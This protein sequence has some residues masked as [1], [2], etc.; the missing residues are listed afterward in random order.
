MKTRILLAAPLFLALA[1]CGAVN[2][3]AYI[4]PSNPSGTILGTAKAPSAST[5]PSETVL[6]QQA[7]ER[8]AFQA[9]LTTPAILQPDD[10]ALACLRTFMDAHGIDLVAAANAPSAA[11]P[12]GFKPAPVGL[13]SDLMVGY[14]KE[15]MV[16]NKLNGKIVIS[17]TCAAFLTNVLSAIFTKALNAVDPLHLSGVTIPQFVIGSTTSAPPALTLDAVKAIVNPPVPAQ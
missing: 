1:A 9:M 7:A 10:E 5:S 11:S 17:P 3:N 15:Q 14:V 6:D 2:P 12:T 13:I 4:D 16:A 8:I